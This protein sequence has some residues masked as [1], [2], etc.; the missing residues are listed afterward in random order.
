MGDQVNLEAKVSDT[1]WPPLV[2]LLKHTE[3]GQLSLD[4]SVWQR[5]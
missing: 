5:R 2:Q 4:F 3:T 1:V